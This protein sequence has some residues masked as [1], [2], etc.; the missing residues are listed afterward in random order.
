MDI[1]A[2]S[3]ADY[4]WKPKDNKFCAAAD[5]GCEGPKFTIRTLDFW[6]AQ[7]VLDQSKSAVERIKAALEL[8]LVAIDDDKEAVKRW[9][10]S[11]NARLVNPL[12]DAILEL[13]SG[14]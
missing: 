7:Q 14:N 2:G 1:Y 11:P 4:R 3:T 6:Q 13:C 10:E 12:F 9:V 5:K 8:G